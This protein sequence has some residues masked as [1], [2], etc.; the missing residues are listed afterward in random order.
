MKLEKLKRD[1]KDPL[2]GYVVVDIA[3]DD[4]APADKN[5]LDLARKIRGLSFLNTLTIDDFNKE[6]RERFSNRAC[7]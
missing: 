7:K 2:Q 1:S 5:F 6:L 3:P 4:I